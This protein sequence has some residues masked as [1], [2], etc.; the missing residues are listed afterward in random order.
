MQDLQPLLLDLFRALR[1]DRLPLGVDEYLLA[2]QVLWSGC[3][4]NDPDE[5]RFTLRMLWA[6]SQEDQA[7]FDEAFGLFVTPALMAPL[8]ALPPPEAQPPAVGGPSAVAAADTKIERPVGAAQTRTGVAPAGGELVPGQKLRQAT[9]P[10]ALRMAAQDRAG[11]QPQGTYQFIPRLPISRREMA[12]IWRHLRRLR[13]EGPLVELD[14]EGTIEHISRDGFLL[15]PIMQPLRGNQAY[16]LMLVD[17][18]ETMG[19]FAPVTRALVESAWGGGLLRRIAVFYF[20]YVPDT[21]LSRVPSLEDPEPVAEVLAA[22]ASGAS[23]LIVS[24]AGAAR[25][26]HSAGRID[27]I[28]AFLES[29]HSHTYRYAWLNPL[30]RS[31]W[32]GATADQVQTMVPMFPLD[33]DGLVDAVG[34]LRGRTFP[35]G[36]GLARGR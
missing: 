12:S 34:I 5:L 31:R 26:S 10:L 36:V 28:R 21:T 23:V 8:P 32:S 4:L 15:R 27:R 16:L 25:R 11:P 9:L 1:K 33:R 22:H 29:L 7:R 6:K 13:R 35:P 17:C 30:P 18:Y 2:L 20:S 14:V 24:D 3:G 19:P